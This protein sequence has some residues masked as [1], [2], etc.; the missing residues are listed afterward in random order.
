MDSCYAKKFEDSMLSL[1][2]NVS[3]A[4]DHKQFLCVRVLYK[5]TDISVMLKLMSRCMKKLSILQKVFVAHVSNLE[6]VF[7]YT[8][9]QEYRGFDGAD[10]LCALTGFLCKKKRVKCMYFNI[11][12][13][14]M[15][16]SYLSWRLRNSQLQYIVNRGINREEAILMCRKEIDNELVD[17]D[18]EDVYGSF[19]RR[20]GEDIIRGTYTYYESDKSEFSKFLFKTT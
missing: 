20:D 15:V 17:G 4:L 11:P 6:T 3:F 14:T 2:S 13:R 19:L 5:E 7:I 16:N 8:T 12:T 9:T 10:L 1:Q 18:H